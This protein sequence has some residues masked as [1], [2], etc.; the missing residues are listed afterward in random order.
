MKTN[1][2]LRTLALNKGLQVV[3]ILKEEDGERVF[4]LNNAVAKEF[5]I[6]ADRV[7]FDRKEFKEE[8]LK[9]NDDWISMYPIREVEDILERVA[10]EFFERRVALFIK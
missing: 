1:D 4:D 9:R 3:A 2:V 10:D 5:A 7:F 8:Y 6:Y